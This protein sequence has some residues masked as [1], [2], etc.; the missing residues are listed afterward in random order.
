MTPGASHASG[1]NGAHGEHHWNHSMA[2][3]S[4][5]CVRR[6]T[7]DLVNSQQLCLLLMRSFKLA[8]ALMVIA[9]KSVMK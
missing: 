9:T 3:G 5:R 2:G 8:N 6:H 4:V 7:S 1:A